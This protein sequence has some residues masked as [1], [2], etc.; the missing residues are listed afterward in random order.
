MGT[1]VDPQLY[2]YRLLQKYQCNVI[3]GSQDPRLL[4]GQYLEPTSSMVLYT[5]DKVSI[6]EY[7]VM[8]R[9]NS[10]FYL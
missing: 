2:S 3:E 1:I 4:S 6:N 7:L 10:F 5:C 8:E 9:H